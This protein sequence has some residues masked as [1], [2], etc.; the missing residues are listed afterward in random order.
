MARKMEYGKWAQVIGTFDIAARRGTIMS[1][2]PATIAFA[3]EGGDERVRLKGFDSAGNVL[4]DL[5][6]DPMKN[7]CAVETNERMFEEYVPVTD[8]LAKIKL[9]IKDVLASE[10]SPGS[11]MPSV[12]IT[13]GPE[14]A[15]QPHRIRL[16]TESAVPKN[17]TYTIQAR[18]QN[19]QR[20]HTMGAGLSTPDVGEI[21][22]RQFP[23]A[24]DLEI[25]VL[26]SDG[27]TKKEVF[28]QQRKL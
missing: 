26:E 20:W 18:P 3:S 10:Y 12:A 11:T 15:D 8:D 28:R 19:D 23:G 22:I 5:P 4:F 14:G 27:L 13:A 17:V 1:M 6:A 9:F 16:R 21:D 25:R 24:T 7:S 2:Q